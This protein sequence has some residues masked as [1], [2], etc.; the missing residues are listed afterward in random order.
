[1]LC[2]ACQGSCPWGIQGN[3]IWQFSCD[4]NLDSPCTLITSISSVLYVTITKFTASDTDEKTSS[5]FLCFEIQKGVLNKIHGVYYITEDSSDAVDIEASNIEAPEDG[6]WFPNCVL[7]VA[8]TK[9][10]IGGRYLH[11]PN[12][13]L[14]QSK[15]AAHICLMGGYS[16]ILISVMFWLFPLSSIRLQTRAL[17]LTENRENEMS[18]HH[19]CALA[20]ALPKNWNI[21]QRGWIYHG[22]WGLIHYPYLRWPY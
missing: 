8:G 7:V 22:L 13:T 14:S 3:N 20:S 11:P 5:K 6:W 21:M 2:Q 19:P 9:L 15:L 4:S 18:D 10:S 17:I 12:M 1:M 16:Q